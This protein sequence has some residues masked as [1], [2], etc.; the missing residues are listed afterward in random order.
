MTKTITRPVEGVTLRDYQLEAVDFLR[1]R[2][3]AALLLDMGLGKTAITLSALTR[4]HLPVLVTAPVRVARSVWPEETSIWR[5]DLKTVVA[6][7]R[8]RDAAL[9]GDL[10]ADIV[11][12]SRDQLAHAVPHG[13][14]FN[15]F[16][17]DELSSFKNPKSQRF[18]YA[19]SITKHTPH[20]W[21]LT[22]TPAPN[23]LLDL[24]AQIFLIDRGAALDPH[25]TKYRAR[26]FTPGPQLP[27]GVITRWDLRP[28]AQAQIHRRLEGTALSMSTEGRVS[29][30]P[31]THNDI[32][33]PLPAPVRTMYRRLKDDLVTDLTD[34]GLTDG[35]MF[36]AVNAAVLGGRLAQ[37]SSGFLYADDRI[38]G[39]DTFTELHSEKLRALDEVIE[40]NGGSPV[41]VGYR[42][43][44]ELARLQARYPEARTIDTAAD[45][46]AW[47]R[48]E[49]PILLVHPA[50]AGHGLNLQ[51]G[52]HTMVWFTAPWSLEEYQQTNKRLA[53]SGQK[54]PVVIHHLISP[55][56]VDVVVQRA[57]TGKA[58][59]QDALLHHLEGKTWTE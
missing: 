15:T 46:A 17:M 53:R 6:E 51:H 42:F 9:C 22:G 37:V 35:A 16:V 59:V 25:I 49:V 54:F 33:V 2:P 38:E 36:S 11:V 43:R 8:D 21:G 13:Q 45:I 3:R 14:R 26:F 58:T 10:D 18:R 48:G 56:T 29:L 31:V 24:W 32:E 20:V 5:P 52:G 50:S 40:G 47:N 34:L 28:G 7:G 27:S 55:G 39:D 41:M 12:I 57:L 1:E 19:K 4:A 23:G 30:P 44:A